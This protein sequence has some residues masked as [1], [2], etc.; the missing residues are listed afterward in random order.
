MVQGIPESLLEYLGL[1]LF[2][3][4]EENRALYEPERRPA[5]PRGLLPSLGWGRL[6][7]RGFAPVEIRLGVVG[8]LLRGDNLVFL[9]GR[10]DCSFDVLRTIEIRLSLL[11]FF[12]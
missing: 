4:F 7:R 9:E 3:S 5:S 1:C 10:G 2:I 12:G 11:A 8:G 6:F